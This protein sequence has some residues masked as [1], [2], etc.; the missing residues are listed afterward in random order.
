MSIKVALICFVFKYIIHVPILVYFQYHF[1]IA[2]FYQ[3]IYLNQEFE[4]M[5]TF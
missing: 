4:L 1:D 3:I 5:S 2:V